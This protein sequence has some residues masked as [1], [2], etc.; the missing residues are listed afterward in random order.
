MRF[1]GS[2]HGRRSG[3]GGTR[4]S[5]RRP[6]EWECATLLD[7]IGLPINTCDQTVLITR[8]DL[9]DEYS[10]STIIR[11]RGDLTVALAGN[12]VGVSAQGAAGIIEV[13]GVDDTLALP[14]CPLVDCDA[15]WLWHQFWSVKNAEGADPQGGAGTFREFTIDSAAMRRLEAGDSSLWFAIENDI[16]S[17][18]GITYWWGMR[19]LLAEK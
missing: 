10:D 3:R 19:F 16:L 11:I 2:R 15:S 5:R 14:Y 4:V 18:G 17:D 13:E 12:G 9:D 8:A 6:K 7:R 1:G